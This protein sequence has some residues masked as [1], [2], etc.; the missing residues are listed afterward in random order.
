MLRAY[1]TRDDDK[2]IKENEMK[3][4]DDALQLG[5]YVNDCCNQELIFDVGDT[6]SRCPKCHR[7]CVW[8]VESKLTDVVAVESDGHVPAL[9]GKSAA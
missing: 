8:E 5:L 2:R 3:T 4:S 6:F 9:S 7:L 1:S